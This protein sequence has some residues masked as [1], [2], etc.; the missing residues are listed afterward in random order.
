MKPVN[1]IISIA[2]ILLIGIAIGWQIKGE[3]LKMVFTVYLP[4]LATLMAAYFG[5]KY[6]FDL[7]SDREK[8]AIK[9]RNAANG[10]LALFSIV[11]MINNLLNYEQQIIAPVRDKPTAFIEM[12]ASLPS[13]KDI[14]S[15]NIESL[16]FLLSSHNPNILGELTVEESKY[17]RAFDAIRERSKIHQKEAIPL[18]AKANFRAGDSYSAEMMEK[19]LGERLFRV[20]QESTKQIITHVDSTILSLQEIE[21]QLRQMLKDLYPDKKI[22]GLVVSDQQKDSKP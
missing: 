2:F 4:A 19:I 14:V 7:Q 20:L 17:Q 22:I 16:F 1:K 18:V 10:N 8:E 21:T 12:K 15:L 5:A 11:R 6:A 13:E 3:N 9:Q